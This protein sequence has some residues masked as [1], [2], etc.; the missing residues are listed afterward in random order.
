ML[1]IF[2]LLILVLSP[3]FSGQ[4]T[5]SLHT[6]GSTKGIPPKL[7]EAIA[8][9]ESGQKSGKS[10]TPWPWTINVSGKGYTFPSK[11][12]AIKAVRSFQTKGFD[13]IDVGVM[14]INLKHHP[15]AFPSLEDAFDPKKNIA[16]AAKFLLN[17]YLKH[18][19]WHT[20]VKHY[21]SGNPALGANYLQ[22][23]LKAWSKT[24]AN[25]FL[26]GP[27]H[28]VHTK[29]LEEKDLPAPK[30]FESKVSTGEK[31]SIPISVSFF[32]LKMVGNTAQP[33]KE[34]SQ[35]SDQK[36]TN[37]GAIARNDGAL[38]LNVT[39]KKPAPQKKGKLKTAPLILMA[40]D[41]MPFR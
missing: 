18:G 13:S 11:A 2:C 4:L 22:K 8:L 25:D 5:G 26:F 7:L 16:Y 36:P 37:P 38:P 19:S 41:V 21:H 14:Q 33:S 10:T 32:P 12:A 20:A 30:S 34:H 35:K 24:K 15:R 28:L 23:V 3:C 17:L 29:P 6:F 9:V 27:M 39:Y 40:T 1:K 31:K